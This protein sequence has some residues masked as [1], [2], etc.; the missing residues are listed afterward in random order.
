[1]AI[2]NAPIQTELYN[3]D[4]GF[5]PPWVLWFQQVARIAGVP[6]PPGP[7]GAASPWITD[8]YAASYTASIA[9]GW[10][11]EVVVTGNITVEVPSGGTSGQPVAISVIQD[12]VGGNEITLGTGW[13]NNRPD[14]GYQEALTHCIIEGIFYD[15]ATVDVLNIVENIPA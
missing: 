5:T 13:R 15:A 9:V 3:E 14:P 4:G 2:P 10:N 6:G 1:M 12:A 11:H 8:P 7:S